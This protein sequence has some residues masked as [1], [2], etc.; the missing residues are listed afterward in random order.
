MEGFGDHSKNKE[1]QQEQEKAAI[2]QAME[3]HDYEYR[4]VSIDECEIKTDDGTVVGL[5]VSP[6][7]N[8]DGTMSPPA[9]VD[10]NNNSNNKHSSSHDDLAVAESELWIQLDELLKLLRIASNGVG[11][12]VPTQL[13]GLLPQ[14]RCIQNK[15]GI[16]Q[17]KD[18]PS[19]FGLVQVANAME[20]ESTI[21]NSSSSRSSKTAV[22]GT[23]SKS[24]FVRVDKN[25]K[26]E[27]QAEGNHTIIPYSALRRAQRLS[28]VVWTLT[29]SIALPDTSTSSNTSSTSGSSTSSNRYSPEQ[30]LQITSTKERLELAKDK[31]E[32]V[33]LLLKKVLRMQG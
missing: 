13:L 29:D 27:D 21:G 28:Y 15:N 3:H 19:N 9:A 20:K 8:Y 26:N 6:L 10:N 5:R 32:Q 1:Q 23:Y 11:V 7:S 14:K 18:W 25:N 31:M 4:R 30:I 16:L 12:P 33:C 17:E 22:V 24:P 2:Q